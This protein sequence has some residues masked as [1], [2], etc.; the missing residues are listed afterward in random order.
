MTVKST[1]FDG[2]VKTLVSRMSRTG[3]WS[4][5]VPMR[6]SRTEK[7]S[8]RSSMGVRHE[9]TGYMTFHYGTNLISRVSRKSRYRKLNSALLAFVSV[10]PTLS[11]SASCIRV[12]LHTVLPP[13]FSSPEHGLNRADYLI[14]HLKCGA[15]SRA[16]SVPCN[17]QRTAGQSAVNSG[18]RLSSRDASR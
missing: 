7:S 4:A 17:S 8:C 13:Q 16:R 3:N 2:S 9:S 14:Q 5:T 1:Q 15:F 6:R 18:H 11:R 10:I 12:Q